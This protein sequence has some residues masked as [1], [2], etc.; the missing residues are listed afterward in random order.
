ML[1]CICK[2]VSDREINKAVDEG[3]CSVE[4]VRLAT[5]ACTQCRK[6]ESEIGSMIQSATGPIGRGNGVKLH[7][8]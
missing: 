6:C 4:D 8:F 7:E 3:A 1:V 5:S 2:R